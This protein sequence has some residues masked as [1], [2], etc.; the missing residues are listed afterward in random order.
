MKNLPFIL[1]F[2]LASCKP[3]P[4]TEVPTETEIDPSV[5][6]MWEDFIQANPGFK[7][8]EIP[9]SWFF[10]N[11][12]KDADR[13]AELVVEG[14]KTAST[15]LYAWY[16]EAGADLPT[17]GTKHIITNFD[18]TAQAIIVTVQVD[19]V[20]FNQISAA[21]AAIDMG[22][23]VDALAQW[24]K[25]HRAFF[26]NTLEESGQKFTEDMLVV[27]EVF[28]TLWPQEVLYEI[29]LNERS[30]VGVSPDSLQLEA[31]ESKWGEEDYFTAMDDLMWY[32]AQM[33]DLL[34]SLQIPYINT[35]RRRFKIVTPTERLEVDNDTPEGGWRYFYF[36]GETIAGKD[37][38][39]L[40]ELK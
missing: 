19:T 5:Y 1:L 34:D 13:L 4:K 3:A 32:S 8:E 37:L 21:Y 24:K 29:K 7:N 31:M 36:N 38:F 35:E 10:H 28:K 11:N 2:I 30:V 22:T 12:Q 40:L 23:E 15:G 9:E 27:C 16:E 14:K 6:K 33:M 18:G 26:Q 39:E 20:P 17:V 25:A